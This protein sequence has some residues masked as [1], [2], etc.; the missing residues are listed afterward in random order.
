MDYFACA[1]FA[2]CFVDSRTTSKLDLEVVGHEGDVNVEQFKALYFSYVFVPTLF[3]NHMDP[4][5]LA[6]LDFSSGC[7]YMLDY[8]VFLKSLCDSTYQLVLVDVSRLFF[9]GKQFGQQRVKGHHPLVH[10]FISITIVQQSCSSLNQSESGFV[11]YNHFLV[12]LFDF[13]DFLYVYFA[14]E[15]VVIV[16]LFLLTFFFLECL[17][18]GGCP[19][20]I[21][22]GIAVDFGYQG[23][24]GLLSHFIVQQFV[25]V[26]AD[27]LEE[28]ANFFEGGLFDVNG[29][30]RVF[31][32]EQQGIEH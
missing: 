32:S 9:G 5:E 8:I 30:M 10:Q 24:G 18:D 13:V 4:L 20:E 6:S 28:L 29:H 15:F 3:S 2:L 1:G 26:F 14:N 16:L 11:K 31:A 7:L 17:V 22:G 21:A 25:F 27:C 12:I 19:L 23:L